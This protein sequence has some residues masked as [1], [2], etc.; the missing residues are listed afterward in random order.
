MPRVE[1]LVV[2]QKDDE[3]LERPVLATAIRDISR[4]FNA[5]RQSGL[6]EEAIITLVHRS[7]RT[8]QVGRE[9][10]SAVIRS[11]ASLEQDYTVP[12]R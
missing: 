12:K 2:K 3:P 5:L 9:E 4:G 7:C 1:K 10:I 8:Y 6:N 11:L